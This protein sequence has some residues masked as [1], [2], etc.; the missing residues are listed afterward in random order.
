MAA[1]WIVWIA[2]EIENQSRIAVQFDRDLKE[3]DW[4]VGKWSASKEYAKATLD[5][6]WMNDKH[7]LRVKVS[8]SGKKG[9]LP[10]GIQIIG[11]NP[12]TGQIVS[13]GSRS[14]VSVE[15]RRCQT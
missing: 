8:M 14:I 5:C 3:L 12:A 11:R 10:G 7:F 13:C 9:D 2:N 1:G 4:M 6:D 15:I